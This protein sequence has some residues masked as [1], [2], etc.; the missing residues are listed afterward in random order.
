MVPMPG[1]DVQSAQHARN[2]QIGELTNLVEPVYPPD[3][4]Q[5]RLEGTVKLHVIVAANGDI[6][7]SGRSAG[8]NPWRKP[9]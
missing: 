3:A 6:Q 5:A 9:R 7:S 8:P 4:R 2:L 1:D